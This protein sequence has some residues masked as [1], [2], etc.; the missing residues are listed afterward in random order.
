MILI[1][2]G[3]VVA[4]PK[5]MPAGYGGEMASYLPLSEGF[6]DRLSPGWST[7]FTDVWKRSDTR[8]I[9]LSVDVIEGSTPDA[10]P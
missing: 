6:G 4:V 5:R 10:G 2:H 7:S 9:S 3:G 8:A 1:F